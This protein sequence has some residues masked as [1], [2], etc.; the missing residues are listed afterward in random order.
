MAKRFVDAVGVLVQARL[1]VEDD[2]RS[3]DGLSPD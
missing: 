2:D 1:E 3:S